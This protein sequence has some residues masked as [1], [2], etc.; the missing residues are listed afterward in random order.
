MVTLVEMRIETRA[1]GTLGAWQLMTTTG[2]SRKE[3]K[4]F[5]DITS[6]N[7]LPLTAALAGLSSLRRRC[8]VEL[9]TASA[10]LA[11]G[12]VS[13]IPV[14]NA[15]GGKTTAFRSSVRNEQLWDQLI[16][17]ALRHDIHWHWAKPA[18]RK[19]AKREGVTTACQKCGSDIVWIREDG[20]R[21]AVDVTGALHAT[22]CKRIADAVGGTRSEIWG[23]TPGNGG[24]AVYA[25]ALAPWDAALSDYREFT[26]A[27]MQDA[28]AC[29]LIADDATLINFDEDTTSPTTHDNTE[30]SQQA[31]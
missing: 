28:L 1:E 25:G 15:N 4:G 18:A 10:Y 19:S 21:V 2:D 8:A 24:S 11:Q 22:T 7:R 5:D 29:E 26:T 3:I 14:W 31:A 17:V 13:L 12:A 30:F 20:K 23:R 16:A 27:E 9:Y 6:A